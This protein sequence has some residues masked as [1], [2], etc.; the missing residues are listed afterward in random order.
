MRTLSYTISSGTYMDDIFWLYGSGCR[1][2]GD[3]KA[4]L[5]SMFSWRNVIVVF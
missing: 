2:K 4:S 5:L 1:I 3:V